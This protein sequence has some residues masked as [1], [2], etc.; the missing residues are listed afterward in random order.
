MPR[1]SPTPAAWVA[2]PGPPVHQEVVPLPS[3]PQPAWGGSATSQPTHLLLP[4]AF[5]AL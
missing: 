3:P 5:T 1:G 2:V 4:L